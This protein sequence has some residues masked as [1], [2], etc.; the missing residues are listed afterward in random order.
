MIRRESV[1][2][3]FATR[4]AVLRSAQQSVKGMAD[5]ELLYALF[6]NLAGGDTGSELTGQVPGD[7][8][9]FDRL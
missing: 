3:C 4:R 8:R 7:G 5:P 6:A 2:D 1:Q 9:H